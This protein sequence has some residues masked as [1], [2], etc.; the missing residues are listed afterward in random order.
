MNS[1]LQTYY[2]ELRYKNYREREERIAACEKR[3]PRLKSLL[4]EPGDVFRAY[5]AKKMTLQQAQSRIAAISAE[6]KNILISLGLPA[7]Y[8]DPIYTCSKCKDTGEVGEGRKKP[9]ACAMKKLQEILTEG[10]RINANETFASFNPSL[11]PTDAQRSFGVRCKGYCEKY[12]AALPHP[13]RPNLLFLGM[14]GL[15]KSYFANAIGYGA[16]ERGIETRKV[17]AYRFFQDAMEGFHAESDPM[18][19]YS[20]IPLL[21]LDDLGTEAMIPNVTVETLF[22]VINERN[23][24]DLATIVVS[25]LDKD[26]LQ[27]TYGERVASRLFDGSRTAIVRFTGDNLRTRKS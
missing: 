23:T 16:I 14:P 13:E 11:Y 26:Q 10:A 20:T 17:T 2:T 22:R 19:L 6:Q 12:V 1:A 4:G 15:G 18:R 27:T 21:I 9:C 24:S 5:A 3:N 25:N 7:S 8:L